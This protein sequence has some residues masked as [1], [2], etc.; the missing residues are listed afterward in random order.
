V[1]TEPLLLALMLLIVAAITSAGEKKVGPDCTFNGKKLYGKVKFV[2]SFPDLKVRAV[3]AFP[4]LKVKM[5]NAFPDKCGLWQS[6]DAF[7]DLKVQM[8]ENFPDIKIKF[9][10]AFP[11]LP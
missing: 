1:K 6:V 11:G 3:D 5:V 10:D 4:D 9:V 2:D 7:P 8:V